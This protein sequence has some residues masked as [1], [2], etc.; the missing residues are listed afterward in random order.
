MRLSFLPPGLFAFALAALVA[1]PLQAESEPKSKTL[2]DFSVQEIERNGADLKPLKKYGY[3]Y[4]GWKDK[5]A[6]IEG[7]GLLVPYLPGTGGMG[8]DKSMNFADYGF[9]V[10]AVVI[11]KRNEAESFALTLIDAD[12]TEATWYLPLGGRPLGAGIG[13]RLDL[14]QPDKEEKPGKTPGL[15]KAKVKKWQIKGNWQESKVEIL[16]VKLAASN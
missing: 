15:N 14:A 5:I 16:L 12:G 2:I 4:E 8:G 3:A 7:K 9:A 13:Y 1:A 6:Y 10:L 11:G